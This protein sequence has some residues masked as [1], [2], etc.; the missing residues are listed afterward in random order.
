MVEEDEE[1]D[2]DDDDDDCK[3]MKNNIWFHIYL[4]T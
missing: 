2:E 3:T 4:L 1:K